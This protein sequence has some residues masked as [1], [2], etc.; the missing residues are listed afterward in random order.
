V[1]RTRH[2]ARPPLACPHRARG[3]AGAGPR[4]GRPDDRQ[5]EALA[6]GP[7][8]GDLCRVSHANAHP[9]GRQG[10]LLPSG[11]TA[12]GLLR[13]TGVPSRGPAHGGE[14]AGPERLF[15]ARRAQG[16]LGLRGL[17]RPAR[18]AGAR[19]I[20]LRSSLSRVPQRGAQAGIVPP[21]RQG[22]VPHETG[23]VENGSLVR[24][25]CFFLGYLLIPRTSIGS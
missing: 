25:G 9:A 1:P 17:S 4:H 18:A 22:A 8:D 14:I 10:V 20:D 6:A 5:P 23:G 15:S 11:P 19:P 12:R 2:D 7:P 21:R 13:A 3:G 16:A 24:V